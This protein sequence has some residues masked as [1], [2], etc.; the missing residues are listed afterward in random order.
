[1][2][3]AGTGAGRKEGQRLVPGTFVSTSGKR[4]RNDVFD[5]SALCSR[6]HW[7]PQR[8]LSPCSHQQHPGEPR[9]GFSHQ[10]EEWGC[11]GLWVLNGPHW[12]RG[13]W[14]DP[15]RALG[16]W[17]PEIPGQQS[18]QGC[19]TAPW[20]LLDQWQDS[21]SCLALLHSVL[22]QRGAGGGSASQ[23]DLTPCSPCAQCSHPGK[24]SPA[25]SLQLPWELLWFEQHQSHPCL[26]RSDHAKASPGISGP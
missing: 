9:K 14:M 25:L 20:S 15:S 21:H 26:G 10:G 8:E 16:F 11:P 17:E 18:H 1:M 19:A 2:G 23:Q 5:L 12:S 24:G 22:C 4:K 6:R 3:H 7:E 13:H